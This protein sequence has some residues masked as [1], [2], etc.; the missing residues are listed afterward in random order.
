MII[1][2]VKLFYENPPFENLVE[3]ASFLKYLAEEE[4][5]VKSAI[6]GGKVLDIGCGEGRSTEIIAD[7]ADEVTGVEFSQR[8]LEQARARLEG[9]DNIRL[10]LEDAIS[11]H[12]EDGEFD[13]CAMLWNTIGNLYALR[14]K[15]LGEARRVLKPDGKIIITA[16]SENVVEPYL[17]MLKINNLKAEHIDENYIFLREGLVSERFTKDKLKKV[18]S[19]VG[20]TAK[21]EP[22]TGI[23]YWCEAKR[24]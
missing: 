4:G 10:Y 2:P 23:A 11:T 7:V 5:K 12:F 22:L 16:F 14:N 1:N 17:E 6:K 21:I 8:L 3:T 9:R 18:L 15:V 20:L 19:D 13:C 24:K